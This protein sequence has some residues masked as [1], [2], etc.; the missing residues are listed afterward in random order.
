MDCLFLQ[1]TGNQDDTSS[2]SES[3]RHDDYSETESDEYYCGT[4]NTGCGDDN[5][6]ADYN[7]D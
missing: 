1:W 5:Y 6:Y 3:Y 2:S 7:N 4:M